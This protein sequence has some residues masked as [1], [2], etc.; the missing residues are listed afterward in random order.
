MRLLELKVDEIIID[1]DR[2]REATGDMEG[3]AQSILVHG[4][5]EPII[6]ELQ[7]D[8]Y[9]LIAGYRR[10]TAHKMNVLDMIYAVDKGQLSVLKRKEIELE[11]N[12]M[13]ED[14]TVAERAKAIAQLD[15]IKREQ[16]PSWSQ[17]MTAAVATINQR[18]VSQSIKLAKA[19]E[20]FPELGLDK[21]KSMNQAMNILENK[22][23]QIVRVQEVK[24]APE[25]YASVEERIWLGDSTEL[26]K[27]VPDE[28]FHLILT[29]PPFGVEYDKRTAGSVNSSTNAYKDD[30]ELYEKIL[31]MAPEMYRTL[32]ANGFLVFF[33]GMSWHTE[34]QARFTAAGFAVDYAPVV[35]D[36]SD[37]RTFTT[38]P[39]HFFTRGYDVALFARKGDA[40]IVQQNRPNILRVPPVDNASKEALVERP[41]E[42]YSE[43]IQRLTIKGERV[44]DF[45]VG[46]G[47]CPAAANALGRDFFGCELNPERRALAIKKITAYTPQSK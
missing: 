9:H 47:S 10:L 2:F 11:E 31:G 16:N 36:R 21:V 23:K 42:L 41:V 13:R 45:F 3:L 18:E 17:G 19:M 4:L 27:K 25:I 29:D 5:L 37:G 1:K 34:V 12:I 8:G 22:A 33:Y 14:M 38:R 32:K 40:K 15:A 7:D 28:S 20:L 39:D 6:V 43:L 24:A 44:A 26:I 35:W 30:K 46:S